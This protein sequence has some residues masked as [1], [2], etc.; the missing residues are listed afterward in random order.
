MF[1]QI[2]RLL[3]YTGNTIWLGDSATPMWC[4]IWTDIWKETVYRCDYL[5]PDCR[6]ESV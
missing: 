4:V 6:A 5:Q 2:L 3:G 1:D